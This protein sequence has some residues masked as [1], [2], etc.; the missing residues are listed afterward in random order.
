MKEE[1]YTKF[2]KE[3]LK[4]PGR[5]G[6]RWGIILQILLKKE[7]GGMRAGLNWLNMET[8]VGLRSFTHSCS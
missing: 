8:T 4:S 3:N 5:P 7:D 6:S 2:C 1:V